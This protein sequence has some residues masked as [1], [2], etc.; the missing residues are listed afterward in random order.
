MRKNGI[1]LPVFSLPSNHGIGTFGK[2]AYRFV[3]FLKKAKQS[4][5][6]ILPVGPTSYGD[7][8]YQS[9][10]TF[11]GNPYF[12]DLDLLAEDGLL[13]K[14]EIEQFNYGN[15]KNYIDYGTMYQ[16]R[17]KILKIAYANGI[18]R[19]KKEIEKF[20]EDNKHW[21]EDYALFMALKN[22]NNGVAWKEWNK[23]IRFRNKETIEKHKDLLKDEIEFYI[24]L[25][26]IF[27]QQ[28]Y[29]LKQYANKNGIEIIGD[30]PIYVAEDSSDVWSNPKLFALDEN[31]FPTKVSGCPPDAFSETGQLWGNPIY[32]WEE[33]EKTNYKWWIERISSALK[34]FDVVRIDH[35]RGFESYWAVPY[36]DETAINGQ[37]EK[38]P[39]YK[40]FEAVKNQ[41]GEIKVIAE[42]LGYI[43]E[44][45]RD[46]LNKC[47]YPGMKVL[48]FAFDPSGE[49]E[50]LP[51]NYE[52][53]TVVYT[54]THDNDTIK[55]YFNSLNQKEREYCQKY[56]GMKDEN[57]WESFIKCA[58]SSPAETSILQMQDIL[59]LGTEARINIPSTL[60]QNWTWRMS[61]EDLK[62]DLA[63][64]LA[65]LTETYGRC[66]R[67]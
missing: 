9:F 2:E 61:K 64:K 66:K 47:G 33:H 46:L 40:L 45:V 56:T 50:Y 48:Q 49:S 16:N 12:I 10:S 44:E 8:P 29:K 27:F 18:L 54:G 28:W 26:Y 52:K 51:H 14:E 19:Y 65:E 17:F 4:Y 13:E 25:Q 6:Q 55:G 1:I 24:F 36:K 60:G 63:K 20:K 41:L 15:N 23:E 43:T 38:G 31:L 39:D 21:V 37:W 34:I 30:I 67:S 5:W 57:D 42:D 59:N 7:S 3:D 32:N 62:D 11:A 35:F 53:N 58:I 22:L